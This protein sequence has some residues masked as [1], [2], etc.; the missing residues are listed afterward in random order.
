MVVS[1]SNIDRDN[2]AWIDSLATKYDMSHSQIVKEA[3]DYVRISGDWRLD[4]YIE[5]KR[6]RDKLL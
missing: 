6:L 4:E 1:K 3:L 5:N 2:F